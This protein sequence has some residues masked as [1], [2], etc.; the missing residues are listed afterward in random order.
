MP[1]LRVIRSGPQRPA[2]NMAVDDALLES[3]E[4]E[5]LRF[6]S[7]RPHALSLG[8]FQDLDRETRRRFE[9]AGFAIV[10]RM[11]GGGAIVHADE[12]T[13]SLS[14][15]ESGP[16]FR[17]KVEASYRLAHDAIVA[18]AA[19]L[20]AALAYAKEDGAPTALR[21]SE[22]P[23]YCF[24]R[25]T[26][27]DLTAAGR[28]IVG[29]AKRRRGGRAVQ[30]GSI[31]LGRS[32]FDAEPTGLETVLGRRPDVDEL[33]DLILRETTRQTDLVAYEGA[34][35]EAE[36]AAARAIEADRYGG[37]NAADTVS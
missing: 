18:A 12:L 35:T 29:S 2:W 34:L 30:H 26:A 5:T 6:Y 27:L 20:G 25:S 14:G 10:R 31:I 13:Y 3:G 19:A 37:P 21:R 24:A 7:W 1:T 32:P 4:A 16:L 22:Q 9:S 23:F 15:P 8:W 28:K 36:T 11:T 33:S 17:G